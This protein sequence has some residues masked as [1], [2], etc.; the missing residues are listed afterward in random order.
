MKREILRTTKSRLAQMGIKIYQKDIAI[1]ET[2]KRENVG[3][4]MGWT[5]D[6]IRVT[7]KNGSSYTYA[8]EPTDIYSGAMAYTLLQIDFYDFRK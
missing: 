5:K 7:L 4:V 3:H 8:A 1:V 6:T 2:L